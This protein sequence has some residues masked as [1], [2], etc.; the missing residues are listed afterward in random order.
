MTQAFKLFAVAVPS[1]PSSGAGS[2]VFV[3][4]RR[5]D[6]AW[7]NTSGTPAFEAYNGSNV[8][9][10]AIQAV[11]N[12]SGSGDY[13]ATDPTPAVEGFYRFF[14]QA[15]SSFA[16]SDLSSGLQYEN[17]GGP[18]SADMEYVLG[19]APT[20]TAGLLAV[21]AVQ[22][23][24]STFT[25]SGPSLGTAYELGVSSS[26]HVSNVDTLATY[27][28][29]TPQTG[30]VFAALGALVTSITSAV[31]A[32]ASR[33]LTAFSFFGAAPT[34]AQ[35][36]AAILKTPANLLATD[37]N[38]SASIS[39]TQPVA[40][41]GNTANTLADC[42]NAARAQGF[43]KWTIIGDTF[44]LYAPDNVTAVRIFTLDSATAPTQRT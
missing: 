24:S 11:E 26:G 39:L 15:G 17:A 20:A 34:T 12:P 43:G 14:V 16:A 27:T 42:L 8:A 38:G 18:G 30:D 7:W 19:T 32:A 22:L 25:L 23:N 37:A 28:G 44:T 31:W 29:N 5:S 10:Y 2:G 21:N 33:T 41:T 13:T 1:L 4:R 36:A 40:T 3:R 9:N 35:T 6:G